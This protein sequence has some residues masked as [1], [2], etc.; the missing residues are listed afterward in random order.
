MNHPLSPD[1]DTAE[2]GRRLQP[3]V[4]GGDI[5][6]Y[7]YVRELHRAYGVKRTI[8]LATQDIKML[9]TSRFTDYRLIEGIHEAENL[10]AALEAVAAEQHAAD[11]DRVLLVLG[12]DDCHARMLSGGK[13][14]LEAAGFVVPYIDFPLLDDITQKRRFYELCDELSIPYPRTWYFD[15]GP[16]GPDKLPADELPYPLIAKPSNSAQFQA[17]TIEGWRKIYEI[18]SAE[19]LAQVWDT[20][21]VSDYAGELVLQD[22]IPGGDDAIRTLTTFSDATGD[23]RVVSGGVVCL[24]DHDPTALG[25]P[26]CIMG[27]REEAIIE[28]ARRF[29]KHTGYRGFANFDIKVDERD[30]S[31]RFFEVNTRAGRNTYYLSLGGVNFATLI[32]DEFVCGREI[33]YREAYD[34]FAYSCVPCYVLRRSMEN[35]ERLA[36]VEAALGATAEPYPLHYA[37]DSFMH[38]LWARI[39]FLNQIPKFKR[40]HWDTGGKQLK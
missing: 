21:R 39:M 8:V 22:F 40:F 14:R 24:Q 10:Y 1:T 27:E 33:P 23:M 11:P 9:S 6:A 29:L 28:H 3:V 5:L 19:E 31:F 12:C 36:Q 38:N 32:V 35:P 4:V 25:N 26:V 18:E 34:R 7:S 30:G 15:C 37:P 2:I 13:E 17:A 16:N 20:I